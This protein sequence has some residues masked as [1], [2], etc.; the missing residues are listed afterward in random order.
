MRAPQANVDFYSFFNIGCLLSVSYLNAAMIRIIV[1]TVLII[2][3]AIAFVVFNKKVDEKKA[4]MCIQFIVV[5]T[6][7]LFASTSNKVW[8]A[9]E[10]VPCLYDWSAVLVRP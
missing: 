8:R 6:F 4:S 1:P 3:A 9:A 5:F 2:L 7:L 10:S